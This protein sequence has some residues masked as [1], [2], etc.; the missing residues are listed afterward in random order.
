[1]LG[2]LAKGPFTQVPFAQVPF[3][4]GPFTVGR[5]ALAPFPCLPFARVP[6]RVAARLI[7]YARVLYGLFDRSR[8]PAR[9]GRSAETS[10]RRSIA[11][12]RS[13]YPSA[14]PSSASSAIR[15]GSGSGSRRALA[16]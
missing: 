11:A 12:S 6:L 16:R 10:V 13:V 5:F 9:L 3:A 2:Q 1:M 7:A 14:W 4:Q 8:R 15:V